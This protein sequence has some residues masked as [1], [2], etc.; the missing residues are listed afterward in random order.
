MKIGPNNF[1]G[2]N[3]EPLP[4]DSTE[5]Q[6][7]YGD[8]KNASS[9][10]VKDLDQGLN[11][12]LYEKRP[13]V[14]FRGPLS[15]LQ[16]MAA[17]KRRSD[18]RKVLR[19]LNHQLTAGLPSLTPAT[20]ELGESIL[21]Q[22]PADKGWKI[23]TQ[24]TVTDFTRYASLIPVVA[25]NEITK[26][27]HIIDIDS[28]GTQ[29]T[30]FTK[31]KLSAQ[32]RMLEMTHPG[33]HVAGTWS[34]SID[35]F[36]KRSSLV[37]M[38]PMDDSGL[39]KALYSMPFSGGFRNL[40]KEDQ[41]LMA[42]L[43]TSI[44]K[45]FPLYKG[46]YARSFSYLDTET[47]FGREIL[48]VGAINIALDKDGKVLGRLD[49]GFFR[50]YPS[51]NE[52]SAGFRAAAQV[53]NLSN[54]LI[55][56]YRKQQGANYSKYWNKKELTALNKY[57]EGQVVF[58]HN[59]DAYDREVLRVGELRPQAKGWFDTYTLMLNNSL[60]LKGRRDL[61]SWYNI[62]TG[63]SM[64]KGGWE[65][66][67]VQADVGAGAESTARLLADAGR[68]G[69]QARFVV[70][71]ERAISLAGV[72]NN[73]NSWVVD[74]KTGEYIDMRDIKDDEYTQSLGSMARFTPIK[75]DASVPEK[76]SSRPP[77][78]KSKP[79]AKPEL[80]TGDLEELMSAPGS[81]MPQSV[82][83]ITEIDSDGIKQIAEGYHIEDTVSG[84]AGSDLQARA[85]QMSDAQLMA[86]ATREL[87]AQSIGD[88]KDI[89]HSMA[90]AREDNVADFAS[91]RRADALKAVER[92]VTLGLSEE[93]A[94][95]FLS[96]RYLRGPND[97]FVNDLIR[98]RRGYAQAYNSKQKEMEDDREH[99]AYLAER[100]AERKELE[101]QQ[102]KVSGFSKAVESSKRLSSQ[103]KEELQAQAQ[104]IV[105]SSDFEGSLYGL[106]E[107]F[108][109]STEEANRLHKSLEKMFSP[110]TEAQWYNGE[111]I[112]NTAQDNLSRW[113]AASKGFVP[114]ILQ[115]PLHFLNAAHKDMWQNWWDSNYAIKYQTANVLQK[116]VSNTAGLVGHAVGGESGERV[117]KMIVGIP[118][119]ISQIKGHIAQ[120]K[121]QVFGNQV[122]QA[123]NLLSAGVQTALVPLKLFGMLLGIGAI[124]FKK[125]MNALNTFGMPLTGLSG[126]TYPSY[127]GHGMMDRLVGLK[128]G[129]LNALTESFAEGSASLFTMGQ[130]DQSRLIASALL[131]GFD[132]TYNPNMSGEEMLRASANR[133]TSQ[134]LSSDEEQRR[135]MMTWI[136]KLDPS[137]TLA[138]TVQTMANL[139]ITDYDTYKDPRHRG[140]YFRNVS[141]AERNTFQWDNY[142]W[143]G[144]LRQLD[145]TKARI[146][147]RLW[148]S[149]GRD[150]MN[151]VN[152]SLD[153]FSQGR[154][155]DGIN[156][157][158]DTAHALWGKLKEMISKSNLPEELGKALQG[159]GERVK[160]WL[161]E[162]DWGSLGAK[163]S[164]IFDPLFDKF[165]KLITMLGTIRIDLSD[166]KNPKFKMGGAMEESNNLQY[167]WTNFNTLSVAHAGS[168]EA[169][170]AINEE[171]TSV[172]NRIKGNEDVRDVSAVEELANVLGKYNLDLGDTKL[173]F[174]D[175]LG[176]RTLETSIADIIN[177]LEPSDWN[178][179]YMYNKFG[180]NKVASYGVHGFLQ[181]FGQ[182]V[183]DMPKR[184]V[185]EAIN[186]GRG[187]TVNNILGRKST[188]ELVIKD[189]KG[190]R[191]TQISYDGQVYDI[192]DK[193]FKIG[194]MLF[195]IEAAGGN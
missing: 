41:K 76:V 84:V 48:S 90:K 18:H 87:F 194:D 155:A 20:R 124:S 66:H 190:K 102:S 53:N 11:K 85:D 30:M 108:R 122:S 38:T 86:D 45:K 44:L 55:E 140:I 42:P 81:S 83:E 103:Q 164:T 177:S 27:T 159:I 35:P 106:K 61:D 182:G 136:K 69:K 91:M 161:E 132:I 22:F 31:A 151:G 114:R 143:Q 36:D 120:N 195:N 154:Y 28:S 104:A 144:S 131:G 109:E 71:S 63:R 65:H 50:F 4:G 172:M 191:I 13:K 146:A 19:E 134:F 1:L 39:N 153:A 52:K 117:A 62:T 180:I 47:G 99:N 60:S 152:Q 107:A 126:V 116:V 54:K 135:N 137:G 67:Q 123:L 25:T 193:Q 96:E 157:L 74:T 98:Y 68:L 16:Q 77:V 165:A 118:A 145:F 175:E 93:Q 163:V 57:I 9:R 185:R 129:S 133:Y 17:A 70:D 113:E 75:G 7:W 72:D 166:P 43:D 12:W 56:G 110:L 174:S 37:K 150:T 89:I 73:L 187:A 170:R 24:K 8:E 46:P 40:D 34:A 168:P 105:G 149:F 186:I 94:R 58:G 78:R 128:Q 178:K 33:Q 59:V 167:G 32:R 100:E 189:D 176:M 142:E 5:Y 125:F 51:R 2:I 92:S 160:A 162:I 173:F 111:Q 3:W 141:Q 79:K 82:P 138:Q 130:F 188:L 112:S 88:M 21:R 23:E 80:S 183:G 156:G 119:G 184:V 64:E 171:L 169:T 192:T 148:N 101:A 15:S 26:E 181:T 10:T 139:G 6:L 158:L 115:R 14:D 127:E 147:H 49:D 97:P 121:M 179:E 29:K 95:D